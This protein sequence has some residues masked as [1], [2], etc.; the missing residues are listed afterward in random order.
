MAFIAASR[1]AIPALVAEVR[2]LRA[3]VREAYE[4]GQNTTSDDKGYRDSQPWGESDAREALG[5][6]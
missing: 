3:L 5:E 2:R 1:E 4:E 6:P